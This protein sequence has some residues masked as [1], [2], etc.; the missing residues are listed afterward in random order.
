MSVVAAIV[1]VALAAREQQAGERRPG[2]GVGLALPAA[3]CFGFYFPPMH[4]AGAGV[5]RVGVV[6][7]LAGV[8]LTSA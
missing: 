5:Q 8:V 1:G 2:A 4:A 3:I 7:T 6:L